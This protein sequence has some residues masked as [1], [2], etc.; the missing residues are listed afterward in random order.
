MVRLQ[1]GA[2]PADGRNSE[3]FR[4]GLPSL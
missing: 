1:L 3:E 4:A 2:L